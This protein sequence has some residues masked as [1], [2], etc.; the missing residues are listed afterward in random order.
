MKIEKP[1]W[2]EQVEGILETLNE[3]VIIVDDCD[4]IVFVNGVFTRLT[5]IPAE[6]FLGQ[7]GEGF[8]PPEDYAFLMEQVARGHAI[9][10]NRYE[11]YLP[12][13]EAPYARVPV[14]I[15][16]RTI[17][18][19]DG[20]QFSILTFTD[21]TE[22]KQAQESLRV[23]NE[24][25]AERQ[26]EIEADLRLAARVQQSLAPQGIRWGRVAVET[27]YLPV[28]TIGGDFGVVTPLDNGHLDLVVCDVSGHGIGSALMAN[29]IYSETMRL[30][31]RRTELGE[32]LRRLNQFILTQIHV[33]GFFMTMAAARIDQK[34]HRLTYAGA[35]HPPAFW[36]TPTGEM[37]R[38]DARNTIIG[39]LDGA[40]GSD[41]TQ[42]VD[43]LPGERFVMYTDGLTDVFNKRGEMLGVEGFE[44][45]VRKTHDLPLVE[46]KSSIMREVEAY[47]EGPLPDDV[48][49][50]LMEFN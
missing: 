49:L 21:I 36:M 29:R 48:S 40:I 33:S 13:G 14:I 42:D 1:E 22:Q 16:G 35:G 50:V 44:G 41:P 24:Q 4:R 46:M 7:T 31:N 2:L 5:G 34:T 10:H 18:D 6:R 9:G 39:M 15:S 47:N 25:L 26:R 37:R 12:G 27:Y 28:R 23:A 45:I 8:Y 17:E 19:P 38:L 32:L 20:R 3:G 11:F 43:L 30:L